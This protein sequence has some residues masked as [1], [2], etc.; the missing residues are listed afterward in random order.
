MVG[1]TISHYR[2]VS[3]LG[4]GGMGVVYLAE[5]ILLGRRVAIK[6][7][8][9]RPDDHAFRSRFLREARA[10]SAF[11]HQH[12]ATIYDYG[13]TGDGQP[14]IVMELIEGRTLCDLLRSG[15]LPFDQTLAII[16]QVAEALSEAHRHGIVHRDIK[17]SNIALTDRGVVKVL[18]FGLAKQINV[19][20]IDTFDPD[21]FQKFNTQTR[22]GV[23]V[24]TPSYFS[25]E[26]A[27][28]LQVDA[29]S[30]LFSLGSVLY[31]CLTGSQPFPGSR[32]IEISA[33]VIR[34]DPALPSSHNSSIP[35]GL[36]RIILKSLAKKPEERYQSTA[37]LMAD[38]T[39]LEVSSNGTTAGVQTKTTELAQGQTEEAKAPETHETQ[40]RLPRSIRTVV[41]SVS[42]ITVKTPVKIAAMI[43]AVATVLAWQQPWKG[44]ESYDPPPAVRRA[45][46]DAVEQIHEGAFFRASVILERVVKEGGDSFPL[47]HAR[48][49]EAYAELD[50]SEKATAELWR[51]RELVPDTSALNEMDRLRLDAV[52]AMVKRDFA[53]AIKNYEAL[54][55]KTP[56]S[57]KQHALIDLGRAFEKS[58]QRSRAI[59]YYEQA[60]TLDQRSP[61]AHLRLGIV[62][63]R[64]Q[65]M[66]DAFN[67]FDKAYGLF[68]TRGGIEGMAEVSLQRAVLLGQ[69]GRTNEAHDELVKALDKSNALDNKDKAVRVLLNLSN[70]ELVAGRPGPAEQYSSQAISLAQQNNMENLTIQG[71]IDIGNTHF[72]RGQYKDAEANYQQAIR[73]AHYYKANR[74]LARANLM[75][76]SLRNHQNNPEGTSE[77]VE[78]ALPFYEQGGYRKELSTALSILGHAY[79]QAGKYNL[80]ILT[81]Q[82]QLDLAKQV[83]DQ[84]QVAQSTEGLGVV[85][86]HQQNYPKALELFSRQYDIAN[87]LRNET[88][89]AYAAMNRGTMLWQLGNYEEA[90][91][92]LDEG[93]LRT[94]NKELIG[95]VRVSKARMALSQG[96]IKKAISESSEV[97]KIAGTEMKSISIQ[98]LSTLGVAEAMNGRATLGVQQCQKAVDLAKTLRDPLP[99]S[100]ALLAL[101]QAA[102]IAK[103]SEKAL[104]TAQEAQTRFASANLY[105][106]EW[107]AWAWIAR[108]SSNS[109]AINKANARLSSL[110]TDWQFDNHFRYLVRPDITELLKVVQP[111]QSA[112]NR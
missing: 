16:K 53:D 17:P 8:K 20:P 100:H 101:S 39:G 89:I 105:E 71:I 94:E 6:T 10:V 28:G 46:D 5:D 50:N 73:L 21:Q 42:R 104:A 78:K 63:G 65:R 12:I 98:A 58:D 74:N 102:Y 96:D 64:G 70:N 66:D 4:E 61:A 93:Q 52:S 31:E 92:A 62:Y 37:D 19:E 24:G 29:R 32:P 60:L 81:F 15:T 69:L 49:A 3:K 30:D 91:K 48:L 44:K 2:I 72:I 55:S 57:E 41:N 106:A 99:L 27:L 108:I 36:D 11:S 82:Q 97:I 35:P 14:Y 111:Q 40:E 75:M 67:S 23:I 59:E 90:S 88:L 76:A 38:L 18:D 112:S 109:D 26:Q 79:D 13:E 45:Y 47:I 51:V 85:Y 43:I 68:D 34:D 103:D 77:F 95:W 22:E 87:E 33:K 110:K 56:A 7:A 84:L 1:L 54:V 9:C 80:A 83:D 107:R 25:P 86:N